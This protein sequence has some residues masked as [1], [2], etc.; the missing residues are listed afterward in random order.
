MKLRKGDKIQV[1]AG[2]NNG[3]TGK[4]LASFLDRNLVIVE[5]VNLYKKHKKAKRQGE[6]GETVLVPRPFNA[7]NVMFLCTAC[8]RP[9]RIGSRLEGDKKNRFCKKCGAIV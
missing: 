1:I 6:K 5:G 2:K 3:K 4:V 7:S 8:G 9:T